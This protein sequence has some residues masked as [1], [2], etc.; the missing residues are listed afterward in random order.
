MR[1]FALVAL[2]FP[3]PSLAE[4]ITLAAP[5]V[6]VTAY[7]RG[8]MVTRSVTFDIPAG[9]HDLRIADLDKYLDAGMIDITLTGAT[10]ASRS[11]DKDGNGPFRAPRTPDWLAAKTALDQATEALAQRDDA[12]ALALTKAEAAQ[13]QIDFLNDLSLPD[14]IPTDI[15]TM[16]AIAQMIASDGTAARATMRAAEI[17]ARALRQ[18]RDDLAFAVETAAAALQNATPPNTEPAT[19]SLNVTAAQAGT[20]TL[21]LRYPNF[22][23]EWAPIYEVHLENDTTLRINRGAYVEQFSAEDWVNVDLTLS[24]L[25]PFGESEPSTLWPLLRRIE[26]PEAPMPAPSMMRAESDMAEE[27]MEAPIMLEETASADLSGVGV[28]YTVPGKVTVRTRQDV[29]RIAL[30]EMTFDATLSARALP[31]VNQT[32]FR[33]VAF[34]NSSPEILLPGQATLY[35]DSQLIGTTDIDMLP[36]NAEADIFFGPI[37]GLRL[38]RVV[39]NRNEGDRGII[40]RSNEETK[41]VRIEVENLTDR[42]W[43]VALRDAVPYS[44]QADLV[45]NYSARPAPAVASVDDQRGILE[46]QFDLPAGQSE[47]IELDTVIRWPDG[48]VLR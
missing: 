25:S 10:L 1:A 13:D 4:V 12:I 26:D 2:L 8:A 6:A 22:N 32:A 24:T 34:E 41:A 42:T 9:Q 14:Q 38:S 23:V 28:S 36:P 15:E 17:E 31:A 3:V 29:V 48:M 46:W 44:E 11:W 18:G 20:A 33:H 39:L 35:V 37:E 40:T 30:G 43:N 16:R 5:P 27:V 45:I 21:T 19:L 7:A 47:M